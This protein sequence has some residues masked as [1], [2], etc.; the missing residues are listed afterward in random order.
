MSVA[1]GSFRDPDGRLTDRD[2]RLL[3]ELAPRGAEGWRAVSATDWFAE[4]VAAGRIAGT[5]EVPD[6]APGDGDV[7]VLE[8]DRL[9]FVSYPDE[10]TFGMLREAALLQLRMLELSLASGL[11]VKDASAF[12][13]GFRGVQPVFLDVGSFEPQRKG[14]PWRA[15]GQF[16]EQFLFPLLVW[17]HRGFDP[18]PA[19]RGRLAGLTPAQARAVLHG[20]DVLRKGVFRHVVLHARAAAR[21]RPA[22]E[23]QSELRKAGF[24]A[25]LIAANVKGLQRIVR[26]LRLPA[27]RSEWTEYH[28][29]KAADDADRVRKEAVVRALAGERRRGLVWDVG[30]NDGHFAR[31]AAEGAEQVIAM[32]S[33]GAVV[34]RL[35]DALLADGDTTVQP[36]VV[37]ATDPTPARGW[38]LRERPSLPERG[39]PELVLVL[40]LVHHLVLSASVPMAE[41]TEWLAGM[42]AEILLEIPERE[43]PM[44]RALLS[45][46]PADAYQAYDAAE[47]AR[48]VGERL[49]V[50]SEETL[51]GGTRRLLRVA[52]RT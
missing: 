12:N 33:D 31:L 17:A 34:E 32:D 18:R 46:K 21:P 25:R 14:E 45:R 13:I 27:Q 24:D 6:V 8:H 23:V 22:G 1:H 39:R 9:P 4:E 52:P 10:W 42:D 38:R 7:A 5:R 19:L 35:S 40:A 37:D 20:R 36:L 49:D 50:R 43:D 16:C 15:Y 41:V 29:D 11:M 48:L 3:R 47:F 30:A 44:V 51:P 28:G 26:G 2:G